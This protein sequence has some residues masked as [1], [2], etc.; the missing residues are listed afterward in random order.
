MEKEI[1]IGECWSRKSLIKCSLI[2]YAGE[3]IVFS[4]SFKIFLAGLRIKLT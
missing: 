1:W 3:E 2:V 4:M